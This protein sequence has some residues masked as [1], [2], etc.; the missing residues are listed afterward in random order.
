MVSH[1]KQQIG[2]LGSALHGDPGLNEAEVEN[3]IQSAYEQELNRWFFS[4]DDEQRPYVAAAKLSALPDIIVVGLSQQTRDH[5][6]NCFTQE[7]ANAYAADALKRLKRAMLQNGEFEPAGDPSIDLAFLGAIDGVGGQDRAEAA[8]RFVNRLDDF[9]PMFLMRDTQLRMLKAMQGAVKSSADIRKARNT[10]HDCI[11]PGEAYQAER[12]SFRHDLT[13]K[14]A[15][16]PI[17]HKG[18]KNWHRM[19]DDARLRLLQY[20]ADTQNELAGN[21]KVAVV[22]DQMSARD[23]PSGQRFPKGKYNPDGP[24]TINAGFEK[25]WSSPEAVIGTVVHENTHHDQSLLAKGY[26]SGT[27]KAEDPRYVAAAVF[28]D[29]LT[30]GYVN[31][32]TDLGHYQNQLVERLARSTQKSVEKRFKGLGLAYDAKQEADLRQLLDNWDKPGPSK[33]RDLS[34][35]I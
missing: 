12:Q 30:H 6:I 17:V 11:D 7:P 1:N 25:F 10:L 14:L 35:G 34:P 23:T 4:A 26:A 15:R 19:N 22:L 16:D 33:V 2:L 28:D 20:V 29:G 5:L 21:P 31:S 8:A 3:P 18:L 32:R 13:E 24:I 27:I 9:Q